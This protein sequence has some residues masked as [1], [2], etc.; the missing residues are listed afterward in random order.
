M[1]SSILRF[2][3][4]MLF[5]FSTIYTLQYYWYVGSNDLDS[6]YGVSLDEKDGRFNPQ[7]LNQ[8]NQP[9][10]DGW[11]ETISAG[12][13]NIVGGT[14][15]WSMR[16]IVDLMLES[17]SWLSPFA[18]IK[19]ALLYLMPPILYQPFNMLILRPLGWIGAWISTEWIINKIRGSSES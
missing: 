2:A 8:S 16:T 9:E 18:L 14:I 5:L 17:V 11:G 13:A 12:L 7:I 15:D 19:G 3:V 4:G 10:P 1:A 6:I